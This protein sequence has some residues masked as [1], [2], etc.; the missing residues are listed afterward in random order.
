M[1][2]KWR[3]VKQGRSPPSFWF[4]FLRAELSQRR[5]CPVGRMSPGLPTCSAHLVISLGLISYGNWEH[6]FL[7]KPY[8]GF[9]ENKSPWCGLLVEVGPTLINPLGLED[10]LDSNLE[11]TLENI[12]RSPIPP[13]STGEGTKT[14]RGETAFLGSQSSSAAKEV[15]APDPRL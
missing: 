10:G 5:P 11:G 7:P 6:S 14:Q 15:G 2:N 4:T 3:A 8:L 9:F 1:V 12:C 13:P